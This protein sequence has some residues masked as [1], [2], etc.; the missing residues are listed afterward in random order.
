M[1]SALMSVSVAYNFF[2]LFLCQ[3]EMCLSGYRKF[4]ASQAAPL[5]LTAAEEELK[6]IKLSEVLAPGSS[7]PAVQGSNINL[8]LRW[9]KKRLLNI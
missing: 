3:D 9:E 1:T 7:G 2:V 5:P 6:Q 4:L 8:Q